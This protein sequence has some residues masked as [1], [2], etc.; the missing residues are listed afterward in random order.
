MHSEKTKIN[1]LFERP[2]LVVH[3]GEFSQGLC[4]HS[5]CHGAHSREKRGTCRRGDTSN[6]S[7]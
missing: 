6:N 2:G 1:Y 7:L 3:T 4:Q 5:Q